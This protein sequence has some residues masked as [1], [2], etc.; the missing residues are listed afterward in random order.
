MYIKI[1]DVIKNKLLNINIGKYK[2]YD[3]SENYVQNKLNQIEENKTEVKI[4]M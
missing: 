2:S 4:L 1:R 3:S